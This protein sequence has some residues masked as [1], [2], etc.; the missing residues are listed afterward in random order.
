MPRPNLSDRD[1]ETRREALREAGLRL[2]R[3]QRLEALT[4]KQLAE[5]AGVAKG[6]VYLYYP[7][8]ESLFLEVLTRQFAVWFR[9]LDEQIAKQPTLNPESLSKLVVD[10]LRGRDDFL[11]LMGLLHP[12]LEN[13][14]GIEQARAARSEMRAAMQSTGRLLTERMADMSHIDGEQLLLEIYA[15]I[16]GLQQLAQPA[17]AVAEA[18][19]E[20]ELRLFQIDFFRS[21]KHTLSTLLRGYEAPYL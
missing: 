10:S 2:F 17:P 21:L 12:V 18:L 7:S 6:T 5:A 19:R 11:R 9:S 13:N 20:Q 16:L 14:V 4:M 15:L 1:K 8:K 3:V